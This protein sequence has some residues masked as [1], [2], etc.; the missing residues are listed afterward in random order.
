MDWPAGPFVAGWNDSW[1]RVRQVEWDKG[2]AYAV[3]HY[4]DGGSPA[5]LTLQ[6]KASSQDRCEKCLYRTVSQPIT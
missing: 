6:E 5:P 2:Q 1:W 3:D 4:S